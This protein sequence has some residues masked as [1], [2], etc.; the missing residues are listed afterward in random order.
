MTSKRWFDCIGSVLL[1]GATAPL[2]AACAAAIKLTS[3]GPVFFRQPRLGQRGTIFRIFKFRTMV[4]DAARN[5]GGDLTFRDDPR[6][7]RIGHV[8]RNYRLDELPQLFNV[9][10]GTMSLVGPRPLLPKYLDA[11]SGYDKR[12]MEVMPGM[13]GWQQVNGASNNTW[14]ERIDLDVWY[15]D[16]QSLLLDI[17]ILLKTI[18]VVIRPTNVYGDDGKQMSGIPTAIGIALEKVDYKN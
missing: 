2:M 6:I 18:F 5:A 3:H 7:T 15:V 17:K 4:T 8:L 9:L 12:R 11:Y 13:T 10:A 16:H 1:I 14:K